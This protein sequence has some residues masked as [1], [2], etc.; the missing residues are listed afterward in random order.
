M[1]NPTEQDGRVQSAAKNC[2]VVSKS[3][4]EGRAIID[5]LNRLIKS[6]GPEGRGAHSPLG[7]PMSVVQDILWWPW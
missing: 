4:T 2:T 7:K 6:K 5:D 1:L 3:D